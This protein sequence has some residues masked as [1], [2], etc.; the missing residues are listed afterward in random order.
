M[1][2]LP[3]VLKTVCLGV[4]ADSSVAYLNFGGVSFI[5]VMHHASQISSNKPESKMVFASLSGHNVDTKVVICEQIS[6][7][8][9]S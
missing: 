7:Q 1:S 2:A 6:P 3:P 8:C 9:G 5:S 4:E